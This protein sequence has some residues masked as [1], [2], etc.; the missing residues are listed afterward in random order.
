MESPGPWPF[1]ED[2]S[3]PDAAIPL[4]RFKAMMLC[5]AVGDALGNP[6]ESMLPGERRRLCGEI[7]TYIPHPACGDARGYPS[8]DTQMAF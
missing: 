6:T 4:E 1:P 5:L 8:D 7:R 3:K 2:D